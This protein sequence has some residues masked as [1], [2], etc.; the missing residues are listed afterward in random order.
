[1]TKPTP[2]PARKINGGLKFALET[3]PVLA[4][5]AAYFWLKDEVFT[6]NGTEYGGFIFVTV[7]FIPLILVCTAILWALTGRVSRM[8]VLTAVMVTVFG[9]LSFWMNDER[10]IK[11]R[12]TIMFSFF[13]ATLA[14]GVWRGQSY[15]EFL[16]NE[17]MPLQHAGWMILTRRFAIFFA[18]MAIANEI[19]WRNFS[20][21][22]YVTV[23]TFGVPLAIFA[24]FMAQSRLFTTYA[25]PEAGS[26]DDTAA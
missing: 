8:Q 16:M 19:V 3:G 23:D 15:L 4:F 21:E 20:T 6:V 18:C 12:P 13:A 26:G 10:F 2:A 24:F 22:T 25:V 1:M 17:L 9:G 11:M 7:A 5:F 14:F